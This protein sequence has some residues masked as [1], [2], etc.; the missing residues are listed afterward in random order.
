MRNIPSLS[1]IVKLV[2]PFMGHLRRPTRSIALTYPYLEWLGLDVNVVNAKLVNLG[3]KA[4]LVRAPKTWPTHTSGRLCPPMLKDA[5]RYAAAVEAEEVSS[6][7]GSENLPIMSI[8]TTRLA[9][10]LELT[11]AAFRRDRPALVVLVQG[12]EPVN[13]VAR[14][15]ALNLGI[16]ALAVENTSLKSRMLWDNVSAITTNRSLA[17]NYYWRYKGSV[18]DAI[19]NE[20]IESLLSGLRAFKTEEHTAPSGMGA[21][22][23]SRPNVLFLAQVLTDSS[24]IFGLGNDESPL[25]YIQSTVNWCQKNGYRLIL[26]LHPKEFIGNDPIANRPYRKLT[27]R[28]MLQRTG[29]MQT[30][31]ENQAIIDS[32]NSFDTYELIHQSK[33]V[34]TVNS[35]AGLEA[36]LFDKPVVVCGNAFYRGLGFTLDINHPSQFNSMMDIAAVFEVPRS[37][38]EFAYIYFKQYCRSKTEDSLVGLIAEQL[39]LE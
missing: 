9:E 13:A 29:L 27:Y 39:R 25:D 17:A 32:E 15:A 18:N 3:F 5:L 30:L 2:P 28:K 34:V 26:K 8:W 1:S 37:C 11:E 6:N 33:F 14:A 36:A 4:D 20:Y 24:I 21:P 31:K 7:T 35:Q 10:M 22:E 23:C 12:Y 19:V 38:R 16:P